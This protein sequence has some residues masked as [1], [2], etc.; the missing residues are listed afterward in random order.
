MAP[1]AE[2]SRI[3][4]ALADHPVQFGFVQPAEDWLRRDG[5]LP[6]LPTAFLP[7]PSSSL[8]PLLRELERLANA[9][10]DQHLI[11]VAEPT[12]RVD[13]R[14][15]HQIASQH[16][17]YDEAILDEYVIASEGVGS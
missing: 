12:A 4:A 15:L 2:A 9:R 6:D 5:V 13:G 7:P 10:P 16:A 1:E 14:A 3:A 8:G 11:L 17:P